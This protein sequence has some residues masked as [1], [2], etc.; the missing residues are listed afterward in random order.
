MLTLLFCGSVFLHS[1]YAQ[2]QSATSSM[3]PGRSVENL[4]SFAKVYGYVKYFHPSD[5]A[6]ELDWDLFAIY[7]AMNVVKARDTQELKQILEETFSFVAP[8]LKIFP[9][10]EPIPFNIEDIT[11]PSKEN[12]K[13]VTWQHLGVGFGN[14]F[15]RGKSRFKSI[16]TNRKEIIL[17][18]GHPQIGESFERDIGSGL[19]C[20]SPLA[21]YGDSEHTY[22]KASQAM[23]ED[24]KA[25][26]SGTDK[27]ALSGAQLFTRL[28]N[29][30]NC[31]NVFQHFYP[32]LEG[33]EKEWEQALRMALKAS[34]SDQTVYDHLATLKKLLAASDD[35]H[36]MAILKGDV[37]AQYYLPIR[38]EWIEGELVVSGIFENNISIRPGDIVVA[39]NG[40][41][42]RQV[43]DS[44]R[45]LVP[46]PTPGY[47]DHHTALDA[48]LGPEGEK[49][50]ISYRNETGVHRETLIRSLPVKSGYSLLSREGHPAKMEIDSSILYINLDEIGKDIEGLIPELNNYTSIIFDMRGY[51]RNVPHTLLGNFMSEVDTSR[52][53]MKYPQIRYPDQENVTYL[54]KGWYLRPRTPKINANLV[55]ILDARAISYAESFMSFIKHYHLGTIVGQP[56]AGT[57]GNIHP[58]KLPGNYYV[59]WTGLKV[60]KHDGSKLHGIGILPDVYVNKTIEGVKEKKDEFLL[61]AIEIAKNSQKHPATISK[62]K[63]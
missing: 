34:Y 60:V 10:H 1:A 18:V 14:H 20:Q 55:F 15:T 29:V 5:E 19:V 44:L 54:G 8:T 46:N 50:E 17:Y 3:A 59:Q 56:S 7:G 2:T 12:Y 30:I 38:W 33:R 6:F 42:A 23:F 32:Y 43:I 37:T 41:P 49:V 51:P 57:N 63:H 52:Y 40:Q 16:R 53:W 28:G 35:G 36:G 58:F 62:G 24:W 48:L 61:K 22:P 31:W 27:D 11:P 13:T 45:Q 47:N 4:Y 39:I 25:F 21:L 9:A 26:E